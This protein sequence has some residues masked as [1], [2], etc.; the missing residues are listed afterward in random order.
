MTQ[1]AALGYNCLLSFCGDRQGR[2]MFEKL[3]AAA[4]RFAEL[5]T[6]IAEAAGRGEFDVVASLA[7]ERSEMEPLITA[8]E[9]YKRLD[10]EITDHEALLDDPDLG[11]LVRD[12]LPGL[13]QARE[14]QE[15]LLKTLVVPKDP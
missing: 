11:A 12:E 15:A 7:R 10:R 14:A 6:Q 9:E 2:P 5:E 1:G 4:Q 8:Y 3:D 13:R